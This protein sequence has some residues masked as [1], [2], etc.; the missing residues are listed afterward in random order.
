[1]PNNTHGFKN[2]IKAVM[3]GHGRQPLASSAPLL[4]IASVIYGA[5][6]KARCA[7]YRHG[8]LASAGLPCRVISV[9]NLTVGGTGKTPLVMYL[10]GLLRQMGRSVT[11]VS[12]GYRGAAERQEAVVSDGQSLL[13][14]AAAAGDEPYMIAR[15]LRDIPVVVGKKRLAAG[16]LAVD[17]FA[18]E[19]IVLDDAM[20]HLRIKRDI[21]LVLLDCRHPFGNG[22]LLPRGTLREPVSSLA[23]ADACLLTRCPAGDDPTGTSTAAL[24]R[25][26]A[27]G[28]PVFRSS[29]V[30][31]CYRI[32]KAPR[33]R[34]PAAEMLLTTTDIDALNQRRVFGFSGIAGNEDFHTTVKDLGFDAAGFMEFDDH[35]RY[36]AADLERIA[37]AAARA[38]AELLIT[39]EKDH[40]RLHTGQHRLPLDLIV[41]GIEPWLADDEAAFIAFIKDRLGGIKNGDV[42][43]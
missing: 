35:Y 13:L 34:R 40:A 26:L 22:H 5:V 30:P 18:P 4:Q 24:I 7:A 29:H 31:Y 19:V 23:R 2:R 27:P 41:V 17:R 36:S 16:M 12:R 43:A 33:H 21:D 28:M 3:F 32:E 37:A 20:Q 9:G 42:S 15:R 14:D 11:I 1:M 39:T 10:A 6:Q 8:V 25:Q 38:D